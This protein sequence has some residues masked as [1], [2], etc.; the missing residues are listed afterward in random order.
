MTR[1]LPQLGWSA[2]FVAVGCH[3]DSPQPVPDLILTEAKILTGDEA[4]PE[5]E[6]LAVRGDRIVA[7]GTAA[8]IEALAGPRTRILRLRNKRVVP[9]FI[10]AHVH[11]LEG[12]F[13]LLGPD[14]HGT[15]SEQEFAERLG[16][17]AQRLP[18]GTWITGG[19]WDHEAWPGHAYPHRRSVDPRTPDHPV[20]VR[21]TDGH[22]A[23]ANT[24]ALALAGIDGATQEPAGGVIVRDATGEPTGVLKDAAMELVSAKI[25]ERSFDAK[26]AAARRAM[27]LARREGVTTI[28]DMGPSGLA[29]YRHLEEHGELTVRVRFYCALASRERAFRESV[30]RSDYLR[31]V[32]IK[33]FADGSLGASTALMFEPFA[34]AP[35]NRG[36]RDAMFQDRRV[37]LEALVEVDRHGMQICT[38]A[39][40][41]RANRE[42]LDVYQ[43]LVDRQGGRDRR[44]RIEHAQHLTP[45]DIPRFAELGVIASVQPYHCIDDGRWAERKLGPARSRWTYAFRSLLDAGA[46]VAFG[47]DWFVAPLDPMRTIHAAVTR[48]TLDGKRPGGWVPA[49]KV[50]VATAIVCSTR[51]GAFAGF[52]DDRLGRITP[53]YLADLV[54]L[55]E[56]PLRVPADR[57]AEIEVETTIVGGRI[58]Y[59]KRPRM[60]GTSSPPS[61]SPFDGVEKPAGDVPTRG[62]SVDLDSPK[63]REGRR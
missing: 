56:D 12:G 9:G 16:E 53:G 35:G 6:A 34:D 43:E 37:F 48:A 31:V 40:G 54:V 22:I 26:L 58:V 55:T 32:G 42:V 60:P 8:G 39:I 7:L 24:R 11:F 10:D 20:F 5:V 18:K 30:R 46:S 44:L 50:D 25:P 23:F 29:V 41:D 21:R 14:L 57:I 61:A 38:H 33:A 36:L 59:E 28:H 4:R 62:D 63:L 27:D 1:I 51:A 15:K 17:A 47:S 45:E 2:L 13:E 49:Q 52:D 19:G 3:G